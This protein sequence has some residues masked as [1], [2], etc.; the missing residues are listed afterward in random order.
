MKIFSK[1]ISIETQQ[2]QQEISLKGLIESIVFESRV[3]DGLVFVF[4]GHTTVGIYL[5][6][7][8]KYLK[9]DIENFLNNKIPNDP[10]YL[11]NVYGGGNA[12][13]HIK[14]VLIGVNVT[15][16]I[17]D[18][19]LYLGEWQDIYLGEF[20]GPRKR[21]ILVKIIGEE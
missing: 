2:K 11:H 4:S 21:K 15:L 10:N 14:N 6:N 5:A 16:S 13:A 18:G 7:N 19:E 20:D 1:W 3:K 17:Y 9:D 8:D 12:S